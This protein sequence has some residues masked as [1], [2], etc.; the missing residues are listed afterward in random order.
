M[1]MS[2]YI[3]K[4]IYIYIGSRVNLNLIYLYIYTYS[5]RMYYHLSDETAQ[6]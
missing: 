1:Y 6:S 3:N 5:H 2:I 4:Y